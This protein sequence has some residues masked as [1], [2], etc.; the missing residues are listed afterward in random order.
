MRNGTRLGLALIALAWL[1][2][3]SAVSAHFVGKAQSEARTH[4]HFSDPLRACGSVPADTQGLSPLYK[5]T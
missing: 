1:T 4:T 2:A 5:Q 3:S